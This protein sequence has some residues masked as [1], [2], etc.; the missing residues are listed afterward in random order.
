M[1]F[2]LLGPV[3]AHANG[4]TV[5]LG[6]PQQR[7]VLAGLLV[8][9]GR[10]VSTETLIDRVWDESP[11]GARRT[12]QVHITR[13]RRLL[14]QTRET[15]APPTALIRR[16]GGYLLDIDPDRVDV[17]RF[18][19]LVDQA[20]QRECPGP[21]RVALLGQALEL[22]RGQALSDLPGQWAE[23]VRQGRQEQYLETVVAW[24]LACLRVDDPGV[25]L[26]RLG[27]LVGEHPL[28]ESLAAAYMRALY[29][30]GRPADALEHYSTVRHRL[31]DKLGTDPGLELRQLHRQILTADPELTPPPATTTTG[32]PPAPRQLPAPPQLFTGR[33]AELTNLAH[34]HNASAVVVTAIDGMAGIG[35]TALAVQAAHRIADRY[36]DGQLFIDLHGHT[37][38]MEPIAPGEALDH[39]LR[40]LG[41]P[42]TQI[43][44]S[45]DQRAALYRTRLADQQM[46]IVLDNA[47]TE[48]QVAPLLPGA[49]GCLV[50]V[51]SRHRLAGLDHTHTLSLDTLPTPDA[52]TLFADTA[53][54]CM[55]LADQPPNLLVELVDLCGRLPLALRIA[56]TRLRSHPSWSLS[57]LVE[58]LRDRQHR[59][60]ELEAGQRNVMAALDLSYEHLNPDQQQTYRLLGLHPGPEFD[61]YATAALLDST[62]PHASRMLDR[63]LEAHLLQEPTP[64]R[65][66]FHDLTRAH[67]AHT[68]AR[69]QT[70]P[71]QDAALEWLL[72]YYRHTASQAMDAAYPYEREDRPQVPPTHT[73]VPDLPCPAP[74]LE[75]LDA[76]LTNLLA[77][78]RCATGHGRPTHVLH[79]STTLHRHLR[80]RGRYHDAETLHQQALATARAAGD[81]AG[82]L[83]ALVGLGDN[84]WLQGR[85]TQAA[86]HY[87]Q[88]LQLARATGSHIDEINALVGLGHIHTLQGRHTQAADHYQQALQLAHAIGHRP[89]EM[90]ALRGLGEIHRLQGRYQPA[91]GHYQ[92][93]LQLA[94]ATGN[95]VGELDA[96]N[97]LGHIHLS[98]SRYQPA[99]DHYQQ[100]LQLART[101]GNHLGEL[102]SLN[103]LG[104]IHRW[105]GRY[106][107]ATDHYQ[108]AL[109]LARATGSHLGELNA[110]VGL[111]HIHRRQGRY[112]QATDHYLQL[113]TVAQESSVR[114]WQ[115]E[116]Q[117]GLGR[118][119]LATGDP[120][121]AIAHHEQALTLAG[122]LNQPDDQARAH[123]GLAHARRALHQHAQARRHWRHA[124][125]ILTSLGIEHTD[126]E[127]ATT[128][129]IRAHLTATNEVIRAH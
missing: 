65:Y 47:A 74:A 54:G 40:A 106:Q 105:Q 66:R 10:P 118:L 30:A 7:L 82:Q 34:V 128:T 97:G 37:Q 77:A 120:D 48:A 52:I 125:D 18:Q 59:L 93:A 70:K 28:V 41:I 67:A 98:Q 84:H 43:P 64:G 23:R 2:R 4:Q 68:A 96:L 32:S 42:G 75:W 27:E 76:E 89:N 73:P 87:Q 14:T 108:Q 95:H 49:P 112:Q 62:L 101:T 16:S 85:H 100:A 31:A 126:D 92:Q 119:R 86:D 39:A 80:S 81:R 61:A 94:R 15:A 45:L 127:E 60:G 104:H 38:G 111:G 17:Y 99:T 90:S 35:K 50:L 122:E 129:A 117:Q 115:Y 79:L 29:A 20:R 91:A 3:E 36:P 116:A 19:R 88:A 69:D 12:L 71:T 13:L 83:A 44:A 9:A 24:A 103:G 51:T 121:A 124:L 114:T 22:W 110:L 109:R 6:R 72:D 123:D 5:E 11:D 53:G 8:D 107:P 78:A 1:E 56:A 25:A 21:E 102:N 55:P 58:R 113:L 63:L 26:P 46:L 33:A 57:H